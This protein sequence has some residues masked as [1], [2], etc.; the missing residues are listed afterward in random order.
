MFEK[1]AKLIAKS[2][3]N[4]SKINVENIKNEDL[5]AAVKAELAA[6]EAKKEDK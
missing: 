6:M 1:F 2:I 5:K 3:K 4:N